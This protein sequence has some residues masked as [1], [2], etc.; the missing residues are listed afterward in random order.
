MKS[1]LFKLIKFACFILLIPLLIFLTI[2]ELKLPK[3]VLSVAGTLIVVY[4]YIAI[5]S[6]LFSVNTKKRKYKKNVSLF[7]WMDE[8][9]DYDEKLTYFFTQIDQKYKTIDN[10]TLIKSRIMDTTSKNI[11]QLKLYRAF[12][13]QVIKEN[14]EELYFKAA[15]A[16]LSS[17]AIYFIKDLLAKFSGADVYS[18]FLFVF[19]IFITIG[20]IS[21]KLSDNKK[22][23]G[24]ILEIIDICI[25]ELEEDG[26]NKENK[27]L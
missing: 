17:V 24:L 4:M 13:N 27:Q 9:I 19:V 14:A 2:I 7:E 3:S 8:L 22:R 15:L 1:K 20:V 10:L 6:I 5:L 18:S 26:L 11:E 23:M 25:E 12:Y 21:D 16:L